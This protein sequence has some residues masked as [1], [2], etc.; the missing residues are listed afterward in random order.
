MTLRS[1][2]ILRLVYMKHDFG[3]EGKL[4]R[5]KAIRY[6]L[7]FVLIEK[8]IQH[9]FVTIAFYLDIAE[10]RASVAIPYE[11]LMISGFFVDIFFVLSLWAVL[12]NKHWATTLSIALALVDVI[13]EFIA[14]GTVMIV[15][16]VSFI[17]AL[18]LLLLSLRYRQL[19]PR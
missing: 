1:E 2:Q 5:L 16:N 6:T 17:V 13:G 19:N 8:I 7:I 12:K 18:V 3:I 4:T 15:C 10:I 9:A 11:L 14:Q